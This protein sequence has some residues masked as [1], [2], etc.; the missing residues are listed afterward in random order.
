[1]QDTSSREVSLELLAEPP[2]SGVLCYPKPT[3]LEAERRIL[4]L[5][6]LGVGSI[7]FAGRTEVAGLH[8]IGKGHV[9]VVVRCLWQG[10][11]GALKVR[12]LDSAR[13]SLQTEGSIL[14]I[15]NAHG[16]GPS[17]YAVDDDF[18]VME[19]LEGR[20]LMDWLE[21]SDAVPHAEFKKVIRNICLQAFLL[22]EAGI[23]HRELTNPK[24]HVIVG[25]DGGAR[26]LDFETASTGGR[27][28]N[29]NNLVQFLAI[30]NPFGERVLG[31]LAA[32]RVDVM[33]AL[34]A[35]RRA[36]SRG[37][38]DSVLSSMNL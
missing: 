38:F 37:A 18:I 4:A 35:Y 21:A 5:R 28:R 24:K 27:K 25:A 22:D 16:L 7:I 19:E 6:R 29:V 13:E 33:A 23:D 2:F 14:R 31:R 9:G 17:L 34:V 12:R 26:V 32:S 20:T 11:R 10:R 8:V 30:A 15:A 1:L 36:P 3:P